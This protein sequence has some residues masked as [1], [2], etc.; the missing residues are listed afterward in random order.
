MPPK[1]STNQLCNWSATLHV[2][3]KSDDD[4]K[5]IYTLVRNFLK[6]YCKKW[7]FSLERGTVNNHLHYQIMFSLTKKL[8]GASL[9]KLWASCSLPSAHMC[10]ISNN[11]QDKFTYVCKPGAVEGPWTS[12]DGD[13]EIPEDV[14]EIKQLREWQDDLAKWAVLPKWL[15]RKVKVLYD[16]P[17]GLGKTTLKRWLAWHGKG[18][19]VVLPTFCDA[20]DFT[21]MVMSCRKDN[22]KC[23]VIDIPRGMDCPKM[24]KKLYSCI[25]T[26]KDGSATEDRYKGKTVMFTP[27][28]VLVLT[29]TAPNIDKRHGWM[30]YDR[31][32]FINVKDGKLISLT[33]EQAVGYG[34][35]DAGDGESDGP[36]GFP[37]DGK[38]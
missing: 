29:N 11:N 10:P 23:F 19:I 25:E 38:E 27:P 6:G 2:E 37:D 5:T 22:T 24:L 18:E 20:K 16:G 30:S 26:L 15:A 13:Q 33:P 28:R 31:W 3:G 8:T 14:A 4:V 21:R 32:D 1:L 36:E 34:N 17:G 12:E 7:G 9:V 35:G